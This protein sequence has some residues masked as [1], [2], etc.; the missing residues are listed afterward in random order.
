MQKGEIVGMGTMTTPARLH[1]WTRPFF[2][3]PLER[4]G[5]HLACRIEVEKNVERIIFPRWNHSLPQLL[6]EFAP[7]CRSAPRLGRNG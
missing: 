7:A 1:E 5:S 3:S 6:S 2:Q 4:K